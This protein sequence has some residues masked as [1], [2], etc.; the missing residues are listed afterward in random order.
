M[1][2]FSHTLHLPPTCTQELLTILLGLVK[3]RTCL[4]THLHVCTLW[5]CHTTISKNESGLGAGLAVQH[6][7]AFC[8]EEGDQGASEHFLV[9]ITIGTF[10]VEQVPETVAWVTK[11]RANVWATCDGAAKPLFWVRRGACW[12]DLDQSQVGALQL[13]FGAWMRRHRVADHKD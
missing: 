7:L 13:L 5:L 12:L 9:C 11:S 3:Q 10:G 8:V 1:A 4:D 6:W 2:R